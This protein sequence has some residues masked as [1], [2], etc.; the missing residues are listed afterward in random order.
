MYGL[1]KHAKDFNRCG[2]CTVPH[3]CSRMR[4]TPLWSTDDMVQTE[5]QRGTVAALTNLSASHLHLGEITQE[6]APFSSALL[7]S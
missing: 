6:G 4:A 2:L 1:I 3:S 5:D 7:D